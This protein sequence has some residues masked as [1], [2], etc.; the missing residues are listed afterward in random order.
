MRE[1]RCIIMSAGDFTP[2]ELDVQE[3]DY[4]IAADNGLTYLTRL[5]IVPDYVIG[6][7]DS[8]QQE[9]RDALLELQNARPD[10]V[11]T[12][13][14]EKDDTDTMAA[15]RE[16]LRRGYRVFYLYGA[17]GGARLDH[18]LAN[19]QTLAFLKENGARA[20]IMDAA[21]MLFVMRD[22][23]QHFGKGFRGD[24]SLFSMDRE[25]HGVTIRGMK[26]NVEDAAITNHFP[27][28]VSNHIEGNEDAMVRVE[29][30]MALCYVAW[31]E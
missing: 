4:V 28:G 13:P 31:R 17:L 9:G 20:Y 11:M 3:G 14:V 27:I 29:D 7:Y 25:I 10:M 16:G 21:C 24:F 1:P 30:G 18:T 12:L 15:A 2:M 26:Y 5:G 6:D 22:E 19:I 23:E 8:L